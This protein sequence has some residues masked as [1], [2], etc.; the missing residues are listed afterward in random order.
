MISFIK[1]VVNDGWSRDGEIGHG[2]VPWVQ[3]SPDF[4]TVS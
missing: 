2:Q 3:L 4:V 1:V